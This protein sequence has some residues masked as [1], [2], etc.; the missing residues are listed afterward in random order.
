MG[1]CRRR[2]NVQGDPDCDH[3]GPECGRLINA[4]VMQKGRQ[5]KNNE[6]AAKINEA[7][8]THE[9]CKKGDNKKRIAAKRNQVNYTDLRASRYTRAAGRLKA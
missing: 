6:I 4:R 8:Q 2:R 7:K 1:S 5:Q 3:L 9:L